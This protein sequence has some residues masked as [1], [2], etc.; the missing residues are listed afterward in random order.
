[1]SLDFSFLSISMQKT[2]IVKKKYKSDRISYK[3][4]FDGALNILFEIFS[5][6]YFI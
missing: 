3:R 5:F 6:G 2:L 1:M 4:I